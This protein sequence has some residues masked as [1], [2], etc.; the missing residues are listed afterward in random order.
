MYKMILNRMCDMNYA[1]ILK[2]GHEIRRQVSYQEREYAQ[3]RVPRCLRVVLCRASCVTV[4]LDDATCTVAVVRTPDTHL[5]LGG[6]NT[7]LQSGQPR[8]GHR[9]GSRPRPWP[10][11]AGRGRSGRGG[12]RPGGGKGGGGRRHA[13]R[14]KVR[15]LGDPI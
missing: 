15:R 4:H 13:G 5:L 2:E 11:A 7:A 6:F 3:K 9:H 1:H 14:H 10:A 8:L 12:S